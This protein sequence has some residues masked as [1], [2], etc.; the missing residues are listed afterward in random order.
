[1][2]N[3][4]SVINILHV[5]LLCLCWIQQANALDSTIVLDLHSERL[6]G[7]QLHFIEDQ[8]KSLSISQV[9]QLPQSHWQRNSTEVF[10]QGYSKSAFWLSFQ[11]ELNPHFDSPKNYFL[12]LDQ[13]IL[14]AIDYYLFS[15]DEII[16]HSATGLLRPSEEKPYSNEAYV[17]PAELKP[18]KEYRVIIRLESDSPLLAPLTIYTEA[19]F[20]ES[21]AEKTAIM[22]FYLGLSVILVLSNLFIY[23]ST[24]DMSFLIYTVHVLVLCWLQLSL[25][26]YTATYYWP[27]HLLSFFHYETTMVAWLSFASCLLFVISF[28]K[29]KQRHPIS[30][31]LLLSC[32][33][34]ALFF[35]AA[36]FVLPIQWVVEVL[37]EVSIIALVLLISTALFNVRGRNK[38]AR[39]FLLGWCIFLISGITKAL[40]YQGWLPTNFLTLNPL[41]IGS[42]LQV[43]LFS[44]ALADRINVIQKAKV[45]AQKQALQALEN[46]NKLKDDFLTSISHELRTPLAGIIGAVSIAQDSDNKEEFLNYKSLVAKSAARMSEAIDSI[47]CLS[48]I[49]SGTLKLHPIDFIF[50]EQ[51]EE[52][53]NQIRLQCQEKGI[54]FNTAINTPRSHV[55]HGDINKIRLIILNLL[56][57]AVNFTSKGHVDFSI[58]EVSD[59]ENSFLDIHVRDTGTGIE[60][61]KLGYIFEAFQQ[62]SGGYTRTQEGLGI[63]LTICKSLADILGGFLTVKSSQGRGTHISVRIPITIQCKHYQSQV[64]EKELEHLHVLIVEDNLV[65]QKIL[66]SITKKLTHSV[67]LVSN[68]EECLQSVAKE[69]PDIILMDCQM[70]IMDGFEATKKLRLTFSKAELPIIA[71]TANALSRD[72]E[73]CFAAGMNDFLSKPI[74]MDDIKVALSKW[75]SPHQ[76]S[77]SSSLPH[78]EHNQ[79]I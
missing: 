75:C 34:I 51:L 39:L 78:M 21:N 29:L 27:N 35:S 74:K 38:A 60:R 37:N 26:G 50:R 2:I 23:L 58:D 16:S 9:A 36:T 69:K 61:E 79:V 5:V 73:R 76:S 20:H 48:E 24:R 22:F 32:F 14:D 6:L 56:Q 67:S 25:R 71:V 42:S 57:N 49:N 77:A 31:K 1:M 17:F 4:K 55:Y 41:F 13:P 65:N 70:P 40:Y 66:M 52:Q 8:Q 30:H 45:N 63:G 43:A 46:S 72:Q 44:L 15:N 68:G 18:G 62:L 10:N 28:L 59:E 11:L 7:N 3:R 47:L 19:K 12:K 64:E 33:Y 54:S 53:L